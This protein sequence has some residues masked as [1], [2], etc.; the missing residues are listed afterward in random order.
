MASMSVWDNELWVRRYWSRDRRPSGSD[1]LMYMIL[2][3][4]KFSVVR[5]CRFQRIWNAT[6]EGR[7]AVKWDMFT[8]TVILCLVDYI[9][10]T[11]SVRAMENVYITAQWHW[12]C[13]LVQEE[14]DD[15]R[16][17]FL[18]HLSGKGDRP[19]ANPPHDLRV[20]N[21]AHPEVSFIKVAILKFKEVTRMKK[22][23]DCW[24][25]LERL[26]GVCLPIIVLHKT[27]LEWYWYFLIIFNTGLGTHIQHWTVGTV[28]N[29]FCGNGWAPSRETTLSCAALFG[30]MNLVNR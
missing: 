21:G 6:E 24:L 10:R 20:P 13:S 2:E 25:C 15:T 30:T 18:P 4:K 9:E 29:V 16:I 22:I 17:L 23:V 28:E 5:S 19:M 27:D 3:S 1:F 26:Q 11:R 12:Q 8:Y 7:V 14:S